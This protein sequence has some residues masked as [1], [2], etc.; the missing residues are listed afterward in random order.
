[1]RNTGAVWRAQA[2]LSRGVLVAILLLIGSASVARAQVSPGPLSKAHADLDG[3]LGCAKCHGKGEGEM[4]RRC[5]ACHGEIKALVDGRRGF[6]GREA[7]KD[8]AHCHPDHGGR[9]FNLVA[10]PDKS[11]EKFD[12]TRTGWKLKGKHATL[13]CKKCHTEAHLSP[14]MAGLVKKK[15]REVV[16]VGLDSNCKS[17]HEDIHRGALGD[18]CASCHSEEGWRPVPGFDHSKTAYPL[19][20]LHAKVVCAKCHEA[21]GLKLAHDEKGAVIPLYKPLPHDECVACHA[22]VHKGAFGAQCSSCHTTAGFKII[23]KGRFDHDKTRYP[24]RGKH[25]ALQCEKCHD[26]KTAWGKKPPFATC[27]GCHKDPHAGQAMLAGKATDCQSCH[28]VDGFKSSTYTIEQHMTSKFPLEGTH[29]SVKCMDCHGLTPPGKPDAV[30]ATL[31]T[32]KVWFHPTHERCANCHRDPHQGRFAPGGERARSKDCLACHTMEHFRP[33]T[34][35]AAQHQTARFKL[36]GAHRATPCAACHKELGSLPAAAARTTTAKTST[37]LVLLMKID[38]STCRDCHQTPHGTQFDSGKNKGACDA[39]HDVESF[40]PASR[41]D[42]NKVKSFSL[43]GAHARVACDKCHPTVTTSE[44]K[45][46]T[47][48]RP[49]SSRCESCH[50]DGDILQKRN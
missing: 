15:N 47:L 22:D 29:A 43:E 42:H 39:C 8:C 40:K 28:T 41:F 31:G 45:K 3:T 50:A 4:D 37:D 5:M 23:Q 17:C 21:E 38:K 11:P 1:M 7:A 14:E 25:A 16:W 20:G 48:Y 46:M 6:H 10:W 18:N 26:E 44:G 30:A 34:F 12:H 32:A 9:D 36:E 33:S 2:R 13:E 27:D 24:L 19:T 35:D 49:I